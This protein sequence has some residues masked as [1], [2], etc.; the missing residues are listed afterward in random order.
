M[1]D[2]GIMFSKP[3]ILALDRKTQTRRLATSYL[4]RCEPGDRLW[5]REAF[6]AE[7]LSRP[8]RT[9]KASA[10]EKRASGRTTVLL[11]DEL[12][13]ADGLRYL[14]DDA[15]V[16]IENSPEAA[17]DWMT[18]YHY[19]LKEGESPKG[20]RGRGIPAMHMPRWASRT[21]LI[22]EAVR[23][24]PLQSISAEDAIAEGLIW[25]PALQAWAAMPDESWPT[26]TD[27]RRSYAGLWQHLHKKEG[28][29]WNDNPNVLVLTF[30]VIRSNI[31][32]MEANHGG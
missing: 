23:T 13:G 4:R 17:D 9:V 10:R 32:Q 15:W 31:D 27:P 22:V 26:F 12:D 7:E 5:V 3:M 29:R 14:A 20:R 16:K 19:G 2:R 21:T 24:E 6:A 30:R 28:E 11:H 1:T 25:R 8:A 18:V